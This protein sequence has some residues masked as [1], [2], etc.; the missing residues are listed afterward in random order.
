MA[1]N[2]AQADGSVSSG[3]LWSFAGREFDESRLELRVN[4]QLVELELKP[5]EILLQLLLNAGKVVTK[6]Q[7]LDAIWPGLTV[8]EGSLTTAI[9]KLRKALGDEDSTIVVTVPKVGYRL[10]ASAENQP[11]RASTFPVE[12]SLN[13]GSPV[14]GRE[15]WHLVRPLEISPNSEVWLAKHPK[16][17]E[18]RVF[19]FASNA[20]R[21]KALRREVT[22]FRFLRESLG[23]RAEFV[24]IFEW[25]FDKHPYFVESEYGGP[26]LAEWAES[27]GGL[28]NI[29]L[30]RRLHMVATIAQA[31]ATAHQAGVLHKD[32][33]PAN[34]LVTPV[35]DGKEQIRIVD[36][37]S[38]S[39][40]EPS[41]LKAL[42]ITNL[43]FTQTGGPT[44]ASLTGTL[45]YLAP[46][47]FCGQAPT[48][49][50]DVYALGV[51][52]YQTVIGDFHKPLS[53]GWEA[54]VR[55]QLL[56]EDIACAVHGDLAQ[57]L[58]TTAELADRLRRIDQR[59]DERTR[60][61]QAQQR[62]R[63]A[64]RK[65][66]EA[67][68]RRPWVILAAVAL[69]IASLVILH[70]YRSSSPPSP[71]LRT[72]AVL[73]FQNVGQDQS[74][75]FL[76]TALPDEVATT[77][78]YTRG[79]SIRPFAVTTKYSGPNLDLQK[80]GREMG[81]SSVV[82]GHF[83]KGG[84]Q[85]QV[86]LEAVDV[87]SNRLLWRDTLDVPAENMIA[88]QRQVTAT[89]REGLAPVLGSSSFAADSAARPQNE[90][91]YDLY[92][93]SIAL[94]GENV[95]NQK[96]ITMLE[97]AVELDPK[98]A[99]AWYALALRYYY[100]S[101]YAGGGEAIMQRS[102]D[103]DERARA[104]DPDS[105]LAGALLVQIRVERG[106]LAEAYR[107][108]TDL[109]HRRPDSADVHFT[110]SYVLR[111]VGL[112]EDAA[113][114]CNVA[115]SLDPHNPGWRSCNAVF[116][117]LGNYDRALDFL[118]LADPNSQWSK[119]H[120]IQ[121]YL[122]QGR[123]KEALEVGATNIPGWQSFT[124]LQACAANRPAKEIAALASAVQPQ[125]D[126][127]LNYA[128][129]AHLAYCGQTS[130]ALRLLMLSIR[131]NHCSYPAIDT[132]PFF[133]GLR[134]NPEFIRIHAAAVAC[135][136]D[137]LAK[138]GQ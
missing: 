63:V 55:D 75:E 29:P 107:E 134:S 94:S 23:E 18:L 43:G 84:D 81:V 119:T 102:E 108:A 7:L 131:A 135:Q 101:Q 13:T 17:N 31:V 5:L 68:A 22:V 79:L 138:R 57:R 116:E 121:F 112:L 129:A 40:I 59:R 52:L 91:A 11:G 51:M 35:A 50:A 120:L 86:T 109:V 33:K 42:G 122:R 61:E 45:L 123:K 24:R 82:T 39:L 99:P 73:P 92:L 28:A 1:L 118:H 85:L 12:L 65:R 34:V 2:G 71:Q 95:P 30:Q 78:S 104:L 72:V 32:L 8:V 110:L 117:Q 137:F 97:R 56:Q 60:L 53:P 96:G 89:A 14:P 46:E 16:T 83:L 48:A 111:Y 20:A 113:A 4:G 76:R 115:R 130:A 6:D 100:K 70:F 62:D 19:K 127:E 69:C 90:E 125:E 132:D 67:H 41:R 133:A 47:V 80:A 114:Q 10:A 106:R 49:A 21:L 15:H 87:Q 54:G 126:P 58:A 44:T 27:Q 25:N 98:Y 88:M 36:F 77:L 26:N 128:F 9:Y 103:A 105:I 66:R 3:R 38:A 124:M 136:K 64:E 93:R 37:G 74:V